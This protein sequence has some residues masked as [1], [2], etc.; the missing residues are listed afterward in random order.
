M[1]VLILLLLGLSAVS[2]CQMTEMLNFTK[3]FV[4]GLHLEKL[5]PSFKD[6]YTALQR[7]IHSFDQA[8]HAYNEHQPFH[9][10]MNNATIALGTVPSVARTAV[11]VPLDTWKEIKRVYIDVFKTWDAYLLAVLIN[12]AFKADEIIYNV[13]KVRSCIVTDKN[14]TCG[15]YYSGNTVNMIFNVTSPKPMPPPYPDDDSLMHFPHGLGITTNW[16]DIHLKF[17]EY[18]NYTMI[19]LNYTKWINATTATNLNSSV[20]NSELKIYNSFMSF[21]KGDIIEGILDIIDTLEYLNKFYNGVYYTIEQVPTKILK[22][23]V[24]EY[25]TFLPLNLLQ[26][27]GYFAWDGYKIYDDLQKHKYADMCRRIAIV[28]RKFLYFDEDVLDDITH[29]VQLSDL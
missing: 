29:H 28:A 2:Y 14:Y 9:N 16:T 15:G 25:I 5:S 20:M 12:M 19:S 13:L 17:R 4:L 1:K 26:H 10:F 3:G 23:T 7:S 18:Y 24:F 6:F 21:S 8:I 27:L 22:D 11:R